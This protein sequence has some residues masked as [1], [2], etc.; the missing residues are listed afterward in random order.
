MNENIRA[1]IEKSA[2]YIDMSVEEAIA[3]FE[4]ICTSNGLEMTNPASIG[5]WRNY[6]ANARRQKDSGKEKDS[7]DSFYKAA[8]GFFVSQSRSVKSKGES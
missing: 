1:E 5:V 4:E 8:F 6:V 2:S 3:K 7:N